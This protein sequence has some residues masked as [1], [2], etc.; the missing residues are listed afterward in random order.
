MFADS[1]VLNQALNLT[2]GADI[3]LVYVPAALPLN[4]SS[5]GFSPFSGSIPMQFRVRTSPSG[6]G[7]I[8]A[9]VTSEFSPSGGPLA[10]NGDLTY[11]C[12]SATIGTLCTAN[13]AGSLSTQ[14]A[15]LSLPSGICT[16]G[17]G[18]C[19]A[20]DPDTVTITINVADKPSFSTNIYAASLTFTVSAI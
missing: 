8:T 9:E 17:G 20:V 11:S 14:T 2:L 18:L 12:S 16:G 1:A 13:T 15:V 4:N 19:T 7:A 10:A 3:K 5:A 6:T